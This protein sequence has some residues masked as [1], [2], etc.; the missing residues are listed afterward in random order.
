MNLFKNTTVYGKIFSIFTLIF[1]FFITTK[2]AYG[3]VNAKYFALLLLTS[4]ALLFFAFR[5]DKQIRI[6]KISKYLSISIVLFISSLF[7]SAILGVD[8]SRS[9]WS[10][11]QRETGLL[12]VLVLLILSFVNSQILTKN[13]WFSFLKSLI[14]SSS[15][16][17]FLYI[18]GQNGLWII[19]KRVGFLNFA[20]DGMTFGNSTFAGAYL[21]L[22][23]FITIAFFLNSKIK[24]E[25]LIYGSLLFIQ[26]ISPIFINYNTL[27]GKNEFTGISSIVGSA[28]ASA[29]VAYAGLVYLFIREVIKRFVKKDNIKSITLKSFSTVSLL[30]VCILLSLLFTSNSFVQK[31][32]IEISTAARIIIWDF[33]FD[34]VLEKPVLGWGGDNFEVPFTKYFDNRLYY[35]ENIGEVWFDRAHNIIVD[36]LVANGFLGLLLYLSVIFFAIYTL[37]KNKKEGNIDDRLAHVLGLVFVGHIIQLQT[38]FDMVSS[39]FLWWSLLAF[40]FSVGSFTEEDNKEYVLKDNKNYHKIIA[41]PLFVSILVLFFTDMSWQRSLVKVF[42]SKNYEERSINIENAFKRPGSFEIRRFLYAGFVSGIH[43]IMYKTGLS[44]DQQVIAKK[45]LNLYI[46]EY[47]KHVEERPDDYRGRVALAYLYQFSTILGEDRLEDSE[48]ILLNGTF[49]LSPNN[50]LA[51]SVLALTKLYGGDIPSAKE[52]STMAL[53]LNPNIEVSQRIYSHILKQEE[54]FPEVSFLKLENI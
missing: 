24:K 31:K 53:E 54:T 10:D 12:T 47:E 18:F 1:P 30:S 27:L 23:F 32:Y 15:I 43:N 19:N 5:E 48:N 36:T 28:Q 2:I 21:A 17:S 46:E 26:A 7:V 40:I 51:Y 13:D 25:K 50:P 14:V 44:E 49:E 6:P 8:F 3:S 22:T 41:I 34:A 37:N 52:Y 35:K 42:N 38:S 9:F 20:T 33:S 11:I 29:V 39:L 16:F 45:E 4:I